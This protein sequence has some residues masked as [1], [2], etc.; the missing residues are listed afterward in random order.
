MEHTNKTVTDMDI[1]LSGDEKSL[2]ESC[3]PYGILNPDLLLGADDAEQQRLKE[4]LDGLIAKGAFELRMLT[5]MS[6]Q[7]E[8]GPRK[9]REKQ[10]TERYVLTMDGKR[11]YLRSLHKSD[12]LYWL[13][14]D[15]R[16]WAFNVG[17]NA[18][19]VNNQIKHSD[20]QSFFVAADIDGP[21]SAVTG[22]LTPFPFGIPEKFRDLTKVKTMYNGIMYKLAED[23]ASGDFDSG[24]E[25]EDQVLFVPN[26]LNAAHSEQCS[27]RGTRKK[28]REVN[29]S[30]GM[31][32]DF[33][34]KNL[35]FVFYSLD[36]DRFRWMP[37]AYSNAQHRIAKE[38]RDWDIQNLNSAK[39]IKDAFFF[40]KNEE[41]YKQVLHLFRRTETPFAHVIPIMMDRSGARMLRDIIELGTAAYRQQLRD[42]VTRKVSGAVPEKGADLVFTHKYR[43]GVLATGT[44]IDLR[45][46]QKIASE[47]K[48]H[49][50][51]PS[52]FTEPVY[53][54]CYPHQVSIYTR[55]VMVPRD[56]IIVIDAD[57]QQN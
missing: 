6:G 22:I 8:R 45:H 44:L 38:L 53:V 1:T 15:D 26:D 13:H 21:Y 18:K 14:V 35:Y 24:L 5:Y 39:L 29:T 37:R 28:F 46:L 42:E 7:T 57:P 10:Q 56:N 27:V 23:A 49:K 19:W 32:V 47:V 55:R 3:F 9:V 41:E 11:M 20:L 36:Y 4:T 25:F 17:H 34:R 43:D 2:V 48:R 51:W 16:Q 40:C 33:I 52:Y 31:I 30:A 12:R 50:K 54:A